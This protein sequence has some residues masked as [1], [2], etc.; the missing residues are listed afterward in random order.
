MI[1]TETVMGIPAEK[2]HLSSSQLQQAELG[3][4]VVQAERQAV[5]E[6]DVKK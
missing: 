6:C 5:R 3:S 1:P 2:K 4:K